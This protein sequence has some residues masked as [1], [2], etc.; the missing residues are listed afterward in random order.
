MYN[1][2][3]EI[4]ND[5]R[6]I[7]KNRAVKLAF[8]K[9]FTKIDLYVSKKTGCLIPGY[10]HKN[11]KN[12]RVWEQRY[13]KKK[14]TS[15]SPH[16]LSRHIY[17][18]E[19]TKEIINFKNK[20]IA[21]LGC[22]NGGLIKL[23]SSLYSF[24]EI[25]GFEA[26]R[27]NCKVNSKK[28]RNK[29]IKFINSSIENINEKNFKQYF[30]VIFLT[31][32]LSNTSNP[33]NILKKI[34]KILKNNG[35]LIIAESSRILVTPNYTLN[36]YFSLEKKMNTFLNYPWRFSFNSL[37]NLLMLFNFKTI[38]TNDYKHNDNMVLISKKTKKFKKNYRVDK[39]SSVISF[40]KKWLKQN[41][42]FKDL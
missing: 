28:M 18:I 38:K 40:F 22:G 17:T 25:I 30:D 6:S 1:I 36:Y 12:L 35:H 32:T 29:R 13:K 19:N 21:D 27:Q 42:L 3:N 37:N 8:L 33:L 4:I 31:W 20:R 24:K 23:L 2:E 10:F 9:K 26:S 16:F 11:K 41:S 34:S 39:I 14:Y 15:N 5:F 7:Y